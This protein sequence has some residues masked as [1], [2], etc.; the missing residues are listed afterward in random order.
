MPCAQSQ[1]QDIRGIKYFC[2]TILDATDHD[3]AEQ[4][5]RRV[6]WQHHL[7]VRTMCGGEGKE[8]GFRWRLQ[9]EESWFQ[10]PELKKRRS[11]CICNRLSDTHQEHGKLIVT[12]KALRQSSLL[13]C[14]TCRGLLAGIRSILATLLRK[15][16]RDS[17]EVE[18]SREHTVQDRERHIDELILSY[19]VDPNFECRLSPGGWN[20][21]CACE[22]SCPHQNYHMGFE[23]IREHGKS[24]YSSDLSRYLLR[25]CVDTHQAIDEFP[26]RQAYLIHS[27]T[28]GSDTTLDFISRSLAHCDTAHSKTCARSLEFSSAPMRL[29]EISDD[30]VRLAEVDLSGEVKYVCLAHRWAT[31]QPW[32]GEA[33]QF[34]PY[35]RS[36]RCRTLRSNLSERK[37]NIEVA[38]LLPTYQDAIS[39]TRRLGIKYL[40][41]DSLCI[42]QNDEHDV[43]MQIAQM[44]NIYGNSYVTIA[45]DT[46]KDHTQSF[47]S[48]RKWRWRAQEHIVVDSHGLGHK[49]FFRQRPQHSRLGWNGLFDR[50]W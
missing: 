43:R 3:K 16:R 47:F 29:L 5:S 37:A 39:V 27:E 21:R 30:R 31:R 38:D 9:E 12:L 42:V 14:T 13:G 45:A 44:G 23:I 48:N 33:D 20:L 41:V 17:M 4:L 34:S 24:P 1:S 19:Q 26:T 22:K 6:D 10:L 25:L 49:L 2:I 8:S 50:A 7:L 28:T 46:L 36:M 40:W 18:L 35:A 11:L 32:D 15:E